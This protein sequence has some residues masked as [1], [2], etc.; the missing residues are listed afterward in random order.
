MV[1]DKGF[2][3]SDMMMEEDPGAGGREETGRA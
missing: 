1:L 2:A 3:K